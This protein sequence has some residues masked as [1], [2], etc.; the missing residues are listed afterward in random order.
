MPR[1]EFR[2]RQA[3]VY[4]SS[5]ADKARWEGWAEERGI[6]LSRFIYEIVEDA[7]AKGHDTLPSELIKNLAE[8]KEDNKK[9][10]E[11]LKLKSLVLEKYETELYR[12][13]YGAFA[14]IDSEG[15]RKLDEE[16]VSLLKRRRPITGTEILE[17]L[18]IDPRDSSLVQLIYNQLEG[19][20]RYGFVSE[21]ANGWRWIA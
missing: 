6:P 8:Q 19:L 5:L 1:A 21:T 16:L 9:L 4:F 2:G 10:R 18:H 11:E 12:L 13:R 15:R 17:E 14:G 3:S 20:S 7:Q